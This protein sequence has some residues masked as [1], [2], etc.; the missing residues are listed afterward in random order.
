[1]WVQNRNAI[2]ALAALL[3]GF[4]LAACESTPPTPYYP[5][6]TFS[7][8][9][10]ISLDVARIEVASRYLAP[11]KPP[12]VEH[13]APVPPYTAIRRWAGHRLVA[14]GRRYSAR[15]VILDAS[16]KEV[17]LGVKGGLKSI[18]T[19]EQSARYDGRVA[20]R[21]EILDGGGRQLAFVTARASRS[22]TVAEG[23]SIVA[24]EKVWFALTEDMLGE[25]NRRL[26]REIR[27]YFR[28]YIVG[29]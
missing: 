17:P 15:L 27:R 13:R 10:R 14:A 26:E 3:P 4:L 21:L 6:L 8:L 20:V 18:F 11:L 5:E 24:R 29:R 2:F 16:I 23:A 28:D 22:E 25:L 9:G 1:M 12:N 7:H 19:S